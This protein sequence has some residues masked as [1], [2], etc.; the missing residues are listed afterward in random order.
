MIKP[1]PK[2]EARTDG[3]EILKTTLLKKCDILFFRGPLEKASFYHAWCFFS[4]LFSTFVALYWACFFFFFSPKAQL[5]ILLAN[6]LPGC[7]TEQSASIYRSSRLWNAAAGLPGWLWGQE[8]ARNALCSLAS[9]E[10]LLSYSFVS[11]LKIKAKHTPDYN[12]K[13]CNIFPRTRTWRK[14]PSSPKCFIPPH[15][16]APPK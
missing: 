8:L 15:L 5:G 7:G 6:L 4:P 16:P 9:V 13:Q 2:K 12:S 10:L 11:V 1:H 3:D 14:S